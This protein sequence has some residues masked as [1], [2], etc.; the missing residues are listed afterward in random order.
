[1]ISSQS[2]VYPSPQHPCDGGK[3]YY[4]HFTDGG[5]EA[6]GDLGLHLNNFTNLIK[7]IG[8]GIFFFCQQSNTGN[9]STMHAWKRGLTPAELV[10]FPN[11][12]I[13]RAHVVYAL[14]NRYSSIP[15]SVGVMML[16]QIP[17]PRVELGRGDLQI[18]GCT[19]FQLT[20]PG[21]QQV[22][23]FL[24]PRQVRIP[25]PFPSVLSRMSL[26]L[27]PSLTHHCLQL[28]QGQGW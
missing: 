8:G 19:P 25:Y 3:C 16:L 2:L 4:P 20:I 28:S 24:S 14:L 27:S 21:D 13:C 1:M 11:K 10:L 26:P 12:N 6:Q 18:Y 7:V 17:A 5:A 23:A 15:T 9:S 22:G